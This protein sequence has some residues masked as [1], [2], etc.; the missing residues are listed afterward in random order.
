[1]HLRYYG[2]PLHRRTGLFALRRETAPGIG[3][4]NFLH[5]GNKEA[6]VH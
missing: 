3:D 6:L 5:G 2:R 1:M 4:R